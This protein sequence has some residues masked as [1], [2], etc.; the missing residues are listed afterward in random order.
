MRKK[1]EREEDREREDTERKRERKIQK[2]RERRI[3]TDR[4]RY[5]GEREGGERERHILEID[6]EKQEK[7]ERE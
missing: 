4:E 3:D 5:K 7:T 6:K 1:N 2:D